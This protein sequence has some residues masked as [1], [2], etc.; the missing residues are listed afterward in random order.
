[1]QIKVHT[2]NI[3]LSQ[4][5]E[6]YVNK[7]VE[8]L[9]RYLPN[10]QSAEMELRTEGRSEQPIAQLTIRSDKGLIF[11][12]EDKKQGDIYAAIDVVVDK[13]YRQL[14]RYKTKKQRAVKG[15]DRWVDIDAEEL[16]IPV[17]EEDGELEL[18]TV[19]EE[20]LAEVVRRKHIEL[21]PMN[22]EEAIEQAELLGHSFFVFLN[23]NSGLV[24]VLY[25]RDD[26]Q[27]GMLIAE[28]R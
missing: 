15:A 1:M 20:A 4:R 18:D 8:R 6:D 22:E 26:G 14:R 28:A 9:D 25:R 16:A 7:K 12:V 17:P 21:T 23:G 13:M 19:E 24:N 5:M 11:R 27:Y 10:I 2:K 3:K